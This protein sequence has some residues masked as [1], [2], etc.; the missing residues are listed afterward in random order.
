LR[1]FPILV[2]GYPGQN[3]GRKNHGTPPED[4]GHGW[5]WQEVDP[6][7]ALKN[8]IELHSR[9]IKKVRD[10]VY[11]LYAFVASIKYQAGFIMYQ[12]CISNIRQPLKE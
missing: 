7:L 4:V 2:A 9:I 3:R 11:M 12:H 6:R 5:P 1:V 10:D 8:S